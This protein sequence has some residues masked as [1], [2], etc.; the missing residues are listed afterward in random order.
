L[1]TAVATVRVGAKTDPKAGAAT[2]TP[3]LGARSIDRVVA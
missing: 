1:S 3:H 2:V